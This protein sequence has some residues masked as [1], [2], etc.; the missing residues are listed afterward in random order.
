MPNMPTT[1]IAVPVWDSDEQTQFTCNF[2]YQMQDM[3]EGDW[4]VVIIDNASPSVYTREF[5][6]SLD[7]PRFH[8]IRNETNLGYGRAANQGIQ[9]GFEHGCEWGIVINNDVVFQDPRWIE[10]AFLKDLRV[11]P[12]WLMGARYIDFNLGTAYDGA[13]IVP[14]LEGWLLAFHKDLWLDLGGFDNEMFVWHEDVELCIRAVKQGYKL[15]QSEAFRWVT[16]SKCDN[17]PVH[18]IYGQT[19][20]AKLNF[21][22][23]SQVSRDYVI[24]KHFTPAFV[25]G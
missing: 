15:V 1:V 2:V 25:S 10:N 17:P 11:N 18:H 13:N 7:D 12:N 23:I 22:A 16:V 3:A 20:F 6:D 21:N 5:L 19:G 8:V 24:K 9:Y 4:L 14:Y